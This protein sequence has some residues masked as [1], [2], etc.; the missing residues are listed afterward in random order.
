MT[1]PVGNSTPTA[2]SGSCNTPVATG[3]SCSKVAVYIRVSTVGQNEAGQRAAIEEYV[4][5]NNL[6]D[7]QWFVDKA[8][9]MRLDRPGFN[10]LQKEIFA[11][12]VKTVLVYKLDRLSR[13]IRDGINIIDDWIKRDVR[14]ISVTQQIDFSGAVGKLVSTVLLAVA[15]MENELRKERQMAGILAAKARGVYKGR[16]RGTKKA[17]PHRAMQLAMMGLSQA[18]IALTLQVTPRTVR[19]YLDSVMAEEEQESRS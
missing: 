18:E 4:K 10:R 5:A 3:S 2:V 17:T 15:E 7:V 6:G 9:G 19:N 14:V 16:K 1:T 8:T 12:T 11:G 13:N